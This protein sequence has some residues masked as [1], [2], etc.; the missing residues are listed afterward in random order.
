MSAAEYAGAE[1]LIVH[2]QPLLERYRCA[3]VVDAC[4]I[5]VSMCRVSLY[6]SG[7][8]HTLQHLQVSRVVVR[9]TSFDLRAHTH[10][11]Q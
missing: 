2:V 3:I 11:A 10:T 8:T 7:H 9:G 1:S 5:R 6:A 4:V